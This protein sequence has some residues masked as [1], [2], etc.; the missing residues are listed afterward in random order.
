MFLKKSKLNP[1]IIAEI[2]GN[3]NQSLKTA[4]SILDNSKKIGLSYVKL[5][6]YKPDTL[7]VN[8]K[9]KEFKIN[10]NH[11]YWGGQNL[12]DLYSKA[13]TPWEW[14][15][16]IFKYAKKIKINCF[17]SPFDETAV[18]FLENC[19]C[20][21]YKVAS[22]EIT[23]IP[24]IEKIGSTKKPVILST[25]MASKSE[26]YDAINTL[27][28]HGCKDYSILKC[29]SSYPADPK[30]ANLLTI[31]DMIK[32]FNCPVGL[33]DHT[34]GIGVS[35][36]AIALGATIIEK[37]I[38]PD[39][40]SNAVDSKFSLDY[41][42]FKNLIKESKRVAQSM[43]GIKYGYTNNEIES[44]KY[45]RSIY[46]IKDIKKGDKINKK[47]IKIIRPNL[48]ELPK[49]FNY[50]LGKK[51]LKNFKKNTPIKKKHVK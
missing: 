30:D 51:V 6:T 32:E 1:I 21:A 22:F 37:H 9:R 35:L 45:R 36:A 2:S 25:G 39:K 46:V 41:Q 49:H 14:H 33:S 48:G 26:I 23:H 44:L 5:Q 11:K 10:Q 31:P 7:T 4:L 18:D 50:M 47:N 20:P 43:G 38:T 16:K 3:H 29:T 15:N 28:K 42:E 24:L 17:S 19:N 13:Y 12:Y 27:S 40:N 8:S 34:P